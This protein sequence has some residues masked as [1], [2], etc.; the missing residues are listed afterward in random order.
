[1]RNLKK[2]IACVLAALC[3]C[4]GALAEKQIVLT[5][6]GDCTVG[7][8]E[9]MLYSDDSF[10]AYAE[11]EGYGYFLDKMKAFFAEDDLTV[12]NFEGVLK[13]SSYGAVNKTYC[14]RGLPEYTQVLTLGSV[15]AVNLANNHSG[16]YGATGRQTTLAALKAAGIAT[17]GNDGTYVFEK[18]GIKIA[19]CGFWGVGFKKRS[20]MVAL[21]RKLKDD[22]ANVVICALHFG[23]EYATYHS[24]TQ[25]KVAH[26]LIDAGADLVVGHHP[27]VVQGMEEYN[28]RSIFFSVGNFLFGGNAAVRAIE[29]LVPRVTLRFSDDGEYLGQQVS[30]YPANISGDPKNNDY[31]PRLV[32][33]D[34]AQAVYDRL[35][36]DS[37]ELETDYTLTD[38]CRIYPFLAAE[39][40]GE[41]AQ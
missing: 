23:E 35:D 26:M 24:K 7:C 20:D 15:E 25:A 29:S 41:A 6:V 37:A 17:F 40:V 3:L 22:G 32:T 5:F 11:R 18:D 21:V 31:Q 28:N 36:A 27:H 38:T 19:F 14:F 16:D 4:S 1:M 33:G 34:A 9:R 12:A 10:A 2:G 13:D 39:T 30:L 8:E